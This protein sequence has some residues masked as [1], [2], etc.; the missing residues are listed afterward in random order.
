[1]AETQI[2]V[3]LASHRNCR[4]ELKS[5]QLIHSSRT[6]S[7]N[8]ENRGGSASDG[9]FSIYI[10]SSIP[11]F[12]RLL[13]LFICDDTNNLFLYLLLLAILISALKT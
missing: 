4:E 12:G 11:D 6:F 9:E 10:F 13:L 1:M 8:G 7:L 2:D 3:A 5:I